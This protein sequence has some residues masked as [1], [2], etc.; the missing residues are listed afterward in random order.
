MAFVVSESGSS[1][2]RSLY[3]SAAPANP[4]N[5]ASHMPK[6]VSTNVLLFDNPCLQ[7][8]RI[9]VILRFTRSA[10]KSA[11]NGMDVGKLVNP[12]APAIPLLDAF[13]DM[14]PPIM[15]QI[16]MAVSIKH[17]V[18]A[19]RSCLCHFVEEYSFSA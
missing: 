16:I 18:V 4:L 14:Q 6:W 3:V 11:T 9:I 12:R 17:D 8:L 5:K 15:H 7:I 19:E 10:A 13:C 2:V 1:I